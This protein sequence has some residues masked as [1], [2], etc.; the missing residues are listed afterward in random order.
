MLIAPCVI[1]AIFHLQMDRFVFNLPK[2]S[3]VWREIIYDI[4]ICPVLNFSNDNEGKKG[5]NETRANTYLYTV[6]SL[7][8]ESKNWENNGSS[9]R[10]FPH[11]WTLAVS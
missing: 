10:D 11:E 6:A 3:C 2:H 4:G 1:L 7:D 8:I 9:L 5:E